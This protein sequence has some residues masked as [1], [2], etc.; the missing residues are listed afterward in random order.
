[1]LGRWFSNVRLQHMNYLE[2]FLKQSAYPCLSP[3]FGLSGS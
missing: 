1:M 2:S 3:S